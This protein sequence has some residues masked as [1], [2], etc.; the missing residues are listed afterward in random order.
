MVSCALGQLGDVIIWISGRRAAKATNG[1]MA[2]IAPSLFAADF[3]ALGKA[4]DTATSAGARMVHLDVCDGHFAPGIT[5]GQPVVRSI[6][7]ATDLE[8][9]VH[10]LIERP[11]RYAEEFVKAGADAVAVH[12]ESTTNLHH[13]LGI[14]KALGAKAGVAL[15]PCTPWSAVSKAFDQFDF[16]LVLTADPG[17]QGSEFDRLAAD[18]VEEVARDRGVRRG[19]FAIHVEGGLTTDR[20]TSLI[21]VGADILV[22]GSAIFDNEDP[23]ARMKEWIRAAGMT[24][25]EVKT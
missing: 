13:T 18:T 7:Q 15:N 23:M 22:V 3:A 5:A 1:T 17:V 11:E 9:T 8:L 24:A 12:P 4:L 6:R 10:L 25:P 14:I 20:V 21:R 16:V 2:L 19:N